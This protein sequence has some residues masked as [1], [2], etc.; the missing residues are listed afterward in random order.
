[1]TRFL[2]GDVPVVLF[3][4]IFESAVPAQ[5]PLGSYLWL[6]H[7]SGYYGGLWLR[8][9]LLQSGHNRMIENVNLPPNEEQFTAEVIG[10]HL[11]P[12]GASRRTRDATLPMRRTRAE[13]LRRLAPYSHEPTLARSRSQGIIDRYPTLSAVR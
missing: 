11:T 6:Y 3:D 4:A 2:F 13:W 5:L 1:M 8:G 10:R 9:E 12:T 7:L